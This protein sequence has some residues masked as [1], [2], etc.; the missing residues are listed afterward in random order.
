M[1]CIDFPTLVKFYTIFG[2]K[3]L[4]TGDTIEFSD[5]LF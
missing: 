1:H 2:I 5:K 3:K 4:S